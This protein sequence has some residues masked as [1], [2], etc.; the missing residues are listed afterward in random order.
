[1]ALKAIVFCTED[2]LKNFKAYYAKGIHKD[3]FEVIS[4]AV[5]QNKKD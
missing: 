4:Y 3:N 1:M 2:T 5:F